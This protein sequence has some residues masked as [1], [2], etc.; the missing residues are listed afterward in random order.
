VAE[1]LGFVN[2]L[3]DQE[4]HVVEQK[5]SA[6]FH[7]YRVGLAAGRLRRRREEDTRLT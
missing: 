1:T 3:V 7:G 6:R 5:L 4:I 2:A